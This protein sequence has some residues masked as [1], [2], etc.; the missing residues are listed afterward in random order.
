M[1]AIKMLIDRVFGIE[2]AFNFT[3]RQRNFDEVF[4]SVVAELGS[5]NAT[6]EKPIMN[7][8]QGVISRLD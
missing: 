4:R 1:V 7:R 5:I 3:D 2:K 6:V 8:F